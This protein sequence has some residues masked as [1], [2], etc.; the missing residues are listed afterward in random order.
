[1]FAGSRERHY[2]ASRRSAFFCAPPGKIVL[3]LGVALTGGVVSCSDSTAP[4][5]LVAA[6]GQPTG[7]QQTAPVG[8]DLPQFLRLRVLDAAGKPVP[9]V[10]VTWTVASGGGTIASLAPQTDTA[11]RVAARWTLGPVLGT[12]AVSAKAGQLAAITFEATA[13][14]GPPHSVIVTGDAQEGAA[15]SLLPLPLTVKV[16]DVHGN[17]VK[18]VSVWW[19]ASANNGTLTGTATT[20]S[21][22]HSAASWTLGTTAGTASASATIHQLGPVAFSA[23]VSPAEPTR[24]T[25]DPASPR[26]AVNG[27]L[28]LAATVRDDFG[29]QHAS[30]V[31]T[32][33]SSD[34]GIAAVDSIGMVTGVALGSAIIFARTGELS[35]SAEVRVTSAD[36]LLLSTT[37]FP[38]TRLGRAHS[39]SLMAEGGVTPYSWTM[40]SGQLPPG[41]T[42]NSNGVISGTPTV[43]GRFTPLIAVTDNAGEQTEKEI[44]MDAC[45]AAVDL[46]VGQSLVLRFPYDCGLM[47]AERAGAVYRLGVMA[48]SYQTSGSTVAAVPGGVVLDRR[49]PGADLAVALNLT[50]A[51]SGPDDAFDEATLQLMRRTEALHQ[52]LHNEDVQQAAAMSAQVT[53]L[54]PHMPSLAVAAAASSPDT[55]RSFYVNNPAGGARK[56]IQARLRANGTNI[57]YY[58]DLTAIGTSSHATDGEVQRLLD[59]YDNHGKVVIDSMFG[60]LGPP[61]TTNNFTGG[62]RLAS[63][64]DGNG[65]FIVLQVHANNMIGGA[66][67]YVTSCDRRPLQVNYNAG[68]FWCSTSNEAEM[69]YLVRPNSAFYLGTVVHEAKHISSHGYAVFGGRGFQPSWIEEGTAEI[70]KESSSRRAS[71]FGYQAELTFADIYPGSQVTDATYGVATVHSRARSFLRAA[72]LNGIAGIPDPNTNNSTYYGSSWL[73][74]RH[75]ADRYAG[76]DMNGFFLSLNTMGTGPEGIESVTGQS[77]ASLLTNFM[78]AVALEGYPAAREASPAR[79]TSYDHADIASRFA[80]GTWPY[81]QGN[82]SFGTASVSLPTYFTS[83]NFFQ[84][85]A[86]GGVEQRIDLL[87]ADNVALLA[88]ID[89]VLVLVRVQ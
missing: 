79:F 80:G 78:T 69:T 15:G 67:G 25:L 4:K 51:S 23:L 47:L 2:P 73:F 82:N 77:F 48:R 68:G 32:W 35:G 87:G 37:E 50:P 88:S 16:S 27:Q 29:N 49:A 57:L 33:E 62:A 20:D 18:G 71:G 60:G 66:A 1:M 46:A 81:L 14:A 24:I 36:P 11:G 19:A 13:T 30:S 86:P 31:F 63:D 59:Y 56:S 85:T 9:N 45:D 5:Q 40:V 64:I 10:A 65:K 7:S 75:L 44:T 42:L 54:G 17:P 61:G 84:L 39:S 8:T 34:D 70:A 28:L 6:V 83:P 21:V 89:A 12:Q 22:G 76:S 43:T 26:L 53:R 58:E 38:V 3:L 55:L 52:R 72:P 41:L 74:H